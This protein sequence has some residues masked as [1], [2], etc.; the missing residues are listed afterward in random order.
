MQ[1]IYA[2]LKSAVCLCWLPHSQYIFRQKSQDREVTAELCCAVSPFTLRRY[3][4][5][6]NVFGQFQAN[7]LPVNVPTPEVNPTSIAEGTVLNETSCWKS[8]VLLLLL[9][10]GMHPNPCC[11]WMVHKLSC[12]I[13]KNS[14]EPC[15]FG[16]YTAWYS[17]PLSKTHL[18]HSVVDAQYQVCRLSKCHSVCTNMCKAQPAVCR[19]C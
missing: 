1:T 10:A 12:H 7:V 15:I 17:N 4:P 14:H 8:Q 13:K 5:A 2:Q 19:P 6:G 3:W 11:H 16:I 9:L 18:A